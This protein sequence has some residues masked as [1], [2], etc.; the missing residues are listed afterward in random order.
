MIK[1]KDTSIAVSSRIRL[2][3]NIENYKYSAVIRGTAK[4][5]E[6]LEYVR[7]FFNNYGGFRFV[8]IHGLSQLE[9]QYLV[10]SYRISK[11][12]ALNE[13][14]A[15]AISDD[16][17]VFIMVNEEDHIREQC[18]LRGLD[19]IGAYSKLEKVD[20]CLNANLHFSKDGN[21]YYT[22]CPTNLGT[23]MRAS[24]MM[25][26]PALTDTR[27]LDDIIYVARENGITFRGAFGE[28]SAA[29]G[30]WYQVSN[31]YTLDR[32]ED[33]MQKVEGFV[34]DLCDRENDMRYRIYNNSKLAF[35]DKCMRS[36]GILKYAK[37]LDS[38]ECLKHLANV[39]LANALGVIP[40]K[41]SGI[42]DDLA[43]T[44]KSATLKYLSKGS[45]SVEVLRADYVNK[46][47]R[48]IEK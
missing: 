18:I 22:S 34:L 24:V 20:K 31:S 35:E 10:E 3:R 48:M 26:L 37:Q 41:N 12:L 23:G 4:E 29:E 28:G 38:E 8:A 9:K 27:K 17:S 7:Q 30:Y 5:K 15:V 11:N 1:I 47:M 2:A 16:E 40:L 43:A 14:G 21:F 42:L 46:A 44:V 32:C 45:D 25:F 36:L 33:V 39:K 6:I 13:N 19:L